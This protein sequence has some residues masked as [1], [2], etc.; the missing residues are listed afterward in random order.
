MIGVIERRLEMPDPLEF[1]RMLRAVVPLMR[2]GDAVVNE[3]V[4]LALL[5]SAVALQFLGAAARRHP[6]F[7]A[8][9]RSLNDLSEPTA[10]LRRVNPVRINR[11]P[12]HVINLPAG[13]RSEEHTSE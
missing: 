3:L 5:H 2:A 8:V 6:G 12:F 7:A 9:V 4:A 1:P 13:K 10:R 11:R